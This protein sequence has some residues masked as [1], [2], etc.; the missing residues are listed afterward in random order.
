SVGTPAGTVLVKDITPGAGSGFPG[1]L[2]SVN[3]TLFFTAT[4]PATGTELWKR[5]GT[6]AGTVLVKD[7]TPGSGSSSP[8][9]LSNAGGTLYFSTFTTGGFWKCDGNTAGT[10]SDIGGFEETS[11]MTATTVN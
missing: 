1:N 5:D 10:A 3:G 7:V 4:D 9:N 6:A 11:R 2:T 8:T